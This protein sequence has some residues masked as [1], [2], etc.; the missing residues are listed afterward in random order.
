VTGVNF[1]LVFDVSSIG[2]PALL[3]TE[4][5]SASDL[6]VS[7]DLVF[8]ASYPGLQVFSIQDP[9]TPQALETIPLPG[10]VTAVQ[11]IDGHILASSYG[12]LIALG[13][14]GGG[15]LA[16]LGGLVSYGGSPMEVTGSKLLIG[17]G[18]DGT[19]PGKLL[20]LPLPCTPAGLEQTGLG[21]EEFAHLVA[22]PNPSGGPI[23]IAHTG[24]GAGWSTIRLFDA[25]GRE[26]RSWSGLTGPSGV[27]EVVWDGTDGNGAALPRG[28]YLAR[29][30]S[31]SGNA[32]TR[33]VLLGRGR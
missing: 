26:V 6:A 21:V 8:A 28:V 1:L 33:V 4:W 17:T 27:G 7:G 22:T 12:N 24:P 23:R 15:P 14:G 9:S 10:E 2:N 13:D 29:L 18:G 5:C 25:G 19:V 32:E 3:G 11:A 20:I 16:L 30:E 31:R